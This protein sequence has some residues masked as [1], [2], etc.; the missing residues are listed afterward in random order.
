MKWRRRRMSSHDEEHR[1]VRGCGSCALAGCFAAIITPQQRNVRDSATVPASGEMAFRVLA[2]A[3]IATAQIIPR[4]VLCGVVHRPERASVG[5]KFRVQ[6]RASKTRRNPLWPG[7]VA[8]E[9]ATLPH[10][11]ESTLQRQDFFLYVCSR[12]RSG[13]PL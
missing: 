7:V 8:A 12:L 11:C 10:C 6:P 4:P 9:S 3:R 13:S 1:A 2:S 5:G